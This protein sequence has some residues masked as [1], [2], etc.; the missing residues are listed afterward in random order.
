MFKL[1]MKQLW[2]RRKNNVW[3]FVELVV[4]T[5]VSWIVLD[6]VIVSLHDKHVPLGYDV[7]RLCLINFSEFQFRTETTREAF[8]EEKRGAL[9]LFKTKLKQLDDV[10]NVCLLTSNYPDNQQNNGSSGAISE[11]ATHSRFVIM[12]GEP[13]L[14]MYGVRVVSGNLTLEDIE[15]GNCPEDGIVVTASLARRFCGTEQAAGRKVS[16]YTIAAVVSDIRMRSS[17]VN[18]DVMI[19]RQSQYHSTFRLL[20]RLKPGVV[21]QRFSEEIYEWAVKELRTDNLHVKNVIAYEDA[22]EKLNGY[23]GYT[24]TVHMNTAFAVFFLFNLCIGV[25]CTFWLQTKQRYEEVGIMRSFGATGRRIVMQIMTEGF[26]LTTA[27]VIVGCLA[28]LQ[29]V[30]NESL[31]LGRDL[32]NPR[33]DWVGDFGIHFLV[34][35][36]IVYLIMLI[37]VG[38]GIYIPA[39]GISR[40]TP[41]DALRSDE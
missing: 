23:N 39:R 17:S 15:N 32:I 21:P 16:S 28:Y 33:T 5:V 31:Y 6:P 41:V 18:A 3:L 12:K 25:V 20:V 11:Q 4:V 8:E 29:Y 14:Q 13:T 9:E 35:S 22:A 19:D 10:E 37:V 1:I 34:V 36:V 26:L 30:W 27:A 2:S 7:E 38:I 40:V 24:N